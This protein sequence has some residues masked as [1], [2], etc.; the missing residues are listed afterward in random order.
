MVLE[1]LQGDALQRGHCT[2]G[3]LYRG[4]ALQKA[5][6]RGLVTAGTRDRR[7]AIQRGL[8][9]E[10]AHFRGDLIAQSIII[11]NS[12]SEWKHRSSLRSLNMW[13]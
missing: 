8:V 4:E 1:S 10:E 2:E 6:D 12:I 13:I 11:T 3:T 7:E 5:R 9:P